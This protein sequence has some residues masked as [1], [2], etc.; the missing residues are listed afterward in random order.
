ML[1]H[2]SRLAPH[3]PDD[4]REGLT[5][6]QQ[7]IKAVQVRL[8][9]PRSD[10]RTHAPVDPCIAPIVQALNDAGFATRASCCGHGKQPGRIT[11]W[12]GRELF[13]AA[14]Y[15]TAQKVSKAFPPIQPYN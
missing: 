9:K 10:G 5:M 1:A 6:C 15:E 12:D 2:T 13:V 8:A 14:D 4:V 7:D 3:A 11:L